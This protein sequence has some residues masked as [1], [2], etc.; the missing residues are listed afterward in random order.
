MTDLNYRGWSITPLLVTGHQWQCA[1]YREQQWPTYTT[2]QLP[3]LDEAIETAEAMV[4]DILLPERLRE[5]T[6]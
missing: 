3:T 2:G 6:H 5:Q 4:D 1:I